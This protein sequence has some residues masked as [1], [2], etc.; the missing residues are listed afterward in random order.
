[1]V[2]IDRNGKQKE[3]VQKQLV[4]L[5]REGEIDEGIEV[6]VNM[7]TLTNKECIAFKN[8]TELTELYD[9]LINNRDGLIP[10]KLR[11]NIDMSTTLKGIEY[12]NLGTIDDKLNSSL[13]LLNSNNNLLI[14][15]LYIYMFYN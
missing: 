15:Y 7:M 3:R 13:L 5:F 14:I 6:I 4:K 10:H 12:K 2:G 11:I 1:M 8:F 9:Y